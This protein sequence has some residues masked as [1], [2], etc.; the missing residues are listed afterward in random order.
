MLPLLDN[1]VAA[2]TSV[3][4]S[5]VSSGCGCRHD[6]PKSSRYHPATGRRWREAIAGGKHVIASH[7]LTS[8]EGAPRLSARAPRVPSTWRWRCWR[9]GARAGATGSACSPQSDRCSRDQLRGRMAMLALRSHV[10]EAAGASSS[11]S[12]RAPPSLGQDRSAP[13]SGAQRR[14]RRA[15]GRRATR[16]GLLLAD[17]SRARRLLACCSSPSTGPSAAT[18]PRHVAPNPNLSSL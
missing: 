14:L 15:R 6:T 5:A 4:V 11:W 8:P 3:T 10:A 7:R 16:Q 18:S 9:R 1:D 12:S 17:F 13:P 2:T